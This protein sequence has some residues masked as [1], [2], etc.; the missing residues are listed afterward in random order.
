MA[1]QQKVTPL[2]ALDL[3]GGTTVTLSPVPLQGGGAPP[4]NSINR[5]VDIIRDRVNGSGISEAEVGKSGDNIIISVPGAGQKEVVDLVGTTAELRFRQ[6]LAYGPPTVVPATLPTEAP[7][8]TPSASASSSA[9]PAPTPSESAKPKSRALTEALADPS[10][11][12][13]PSPSTTGTGK[14]AE[15]P[16]PGSTADPTGVPTVTPSPAVPADPLAGIDTTGIDPAVLEQF[17][18]L[19]CTAKDRGQGTVDDPGKQF[20]AC[21]DAGAGKYILEK[22]DIVG[23]EVSTASSGIDPTSNEWVVQVEFKNEGGKKFAQLTSRVNLQQIP[24]GPRNQ[25][26]MVLDGVVISAPVINEPIPGGTA[27]ISGGFEQKDAEDLANQ[28]KYGALPLKFEKSSI[29]SVSST[30]GADQ[31]NGGLLAG[32]IGLILVVIYSLFYYR[33]LGVVSVLS[34]LIAG[35]L[36]YQSVVILG[37]GIGFRLSLAHIIGLIVSIGITADSFIV[38]FERLRDELKAG[39]PIRPAVEIAW[40]RARRTI[41]VADA[42]TFIAAVVLYFLSVGGVA[43]FAFAMGLTTLIDIAVVFLFTKPLVALLCRTKF[44]A[45]G[46][47]LSGL[48]QDRLRSVSAVR[49]TPQEA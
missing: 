44:F 3:A 26:A 22:A 8:P 24:Q 31:L 1:L 38:Y 2:Y 21:D 39:R 35:I 7:T 30:L 42:V 34:L 27:Q 29:E 49:T 10:H 37:H 15:T 4:E 45:Q 6:V 16:K 43:G 28:L 23:T 18:T 41:L 47:K 33:G 48:D 17:K 12:P 19:D 5:A 25:V 13:T 32:G 40:R 20:V 11:P 36:T 46:H 14:P 9:K